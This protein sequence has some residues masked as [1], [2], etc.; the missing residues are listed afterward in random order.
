MTL[1]WANIGDL[2]DQAEQQGQG[3]EIAEQNSKTEG[4][5]FMENEWF[6]VDS[7]TE[8]P[9]HILENQAKAK[10][11]EIQEH[12]DRINDLIDIGELQEA[13]AQALTQWYITEKRYNELLEMEPGDAVYAM[14]KLIDFVNTPAVEPEPKW[15]EI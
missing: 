11:Q 13:L 2:I 15:Q 6:W 7:N 12:K 5:I 3:A 4:D 1:E 9:D 14:K 10:Q 8:V